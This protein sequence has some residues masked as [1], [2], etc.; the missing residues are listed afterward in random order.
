MNNPINECIACFLL[1]VVSFFAYK[2]FNKM[3]KKENAQL[4]ERLTTFNLLVGSIVFFFMF[5]I[6][7]FRLLGN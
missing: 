7:L 1:S 2:I 4:T 5:L 6:C 3:D